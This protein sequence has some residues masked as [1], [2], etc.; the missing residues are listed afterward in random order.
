[1]KQVFNAGKT[2]T[3][4]KLIIKIIIIIKNKNRKLEKKIWKNTK[5]K[6]QNSATV[7]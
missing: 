1:M 5:L 6:G 3:A 4:P 7:V 2:T